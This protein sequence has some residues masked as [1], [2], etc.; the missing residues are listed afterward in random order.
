MKRAFEVLRPDYILIDGNKMPKTEVPGEAI[1]KGD[2]KSPSI[3][4]ASIIAKHTRDQMMLHLHAEYPAYNFAKHKGYPTKEHIDALTLHGPSPIHR[5]SF[6]PVR[7][8]KQ[9]KKGE[10]QCKVHIQ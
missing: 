1:I 4:A 5:L 8:L 7:K 2:G 10:Y 6:A 3:A 9:K